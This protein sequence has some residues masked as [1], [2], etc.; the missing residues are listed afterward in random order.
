MKKGNNDKKSVP[1]SLKDSSSSK[2][3]DK[4]AHLE[5]N[6]AKLTK[7]GVDTD[8]RVGEVSY[9]PSKTCFRYRM[10]TTTYEIRGYSKSDSKIQ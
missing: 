10:E 2:Y 5:N 9:L 4:L 3:Y 1:T 6:N 7:Q 8:E